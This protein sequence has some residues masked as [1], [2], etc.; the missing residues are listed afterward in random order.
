MLQPATHVPNV[1]LAESGPTGFI[2]PTVPYVFAFALGHAPA[3]DTHIPL[4][5]VVTIAVADGT[6]AHHDPHDW[7]AARVPAIPAVTGPVRV[8]G[9]R[10]GDLLEIEV[11]ALEPNDPGSIGPFK[12]TVVVAS[13]KAGRSVDPIES[14]IPVGGT[15]RVTAQHPSAWISFGPVVTKREHNGDPRGE[16]VA[17]RMHVRCTVAQSLGI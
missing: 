2:Q 4:G 7:F 10:Q 9:V 15:V 13:G 11:I 3:M 17:A 12:V 1:A 16:P 6:R 8:T 14:T 5:K